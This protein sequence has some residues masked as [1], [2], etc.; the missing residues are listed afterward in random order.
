[1][2][3]AQLGTTSRRWL[4]R[5]QV[6]RL[7]RLREVSVM[8]S[9]ANGRSWSSLSK[10][11][12]VASGCFALTTHSQFNNPMSRNVKRLAT[13]TALVAPIT[14]SVRSSASA[15]HTPLYTSYSSSNS[16]SGN[17]R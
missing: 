11:A 7:G 16:T 9:E 14:M 4:S 13:G 10:P 5:V 6:S 1:M 15:S 8:Q 3:E 2:A 12:A 17:C